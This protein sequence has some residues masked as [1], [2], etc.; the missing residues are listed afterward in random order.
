MSV[1]YSLERYPIILGDVRTKTPSL[2]QGPIN[3]VMPMGTCCSILEY[4][5]GI[6]FQDT[7]SFYQEKA[8]LLSPPRSRKEDCLGVTCT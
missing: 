4:Q 5:Q 6:L 2:N 1:G 8:K 7:L 3:E